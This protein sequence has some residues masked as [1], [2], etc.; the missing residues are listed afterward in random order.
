MDWVN[1]ITPHNLEECSNK[2]VVNKMSSWLESWEKK[3]TVDNI[4][5]A[6]LLHGPSGTGKTLY[7]KLLLNNM[8]ITKSYIFQQMI[9]EH[10]LDL[11]K[12]I[13]KFIKNFTFLSLLKRLKK[14]LYLMN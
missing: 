14:L 9:S 7:A 10:T 12:R 4:K 11:T 2:I 5:N 1:D 3:T 6:I 13:D 8:V